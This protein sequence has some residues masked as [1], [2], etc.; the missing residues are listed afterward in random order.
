MIPVVLIV[1]TFFFPF[2]S[3]LPVLVALLLA[4]HWKTKMLYAGLFTWCIATLS[5]LYIPLPDM[6]MSRYYTLME[7]LNTQPIHA[8]LGFIWSNTDPISYTLMYIFQAPWSAPAL[9]SWMTVVVC[10]GLYFSIFIDRYRRKTL[11]LHMFAGVVLAFLSAFILFNAVSGVRFNIAVA[12]VVWT[13]YWLGVASRYK[14]ALYC[15]LAITPLIHSSMLGVVGLYAVVVLFRHVRFLNVVLLTVGVAMSI[16]V[17][18]GLAQYISFMPF[19]NEVET[20]AVYYLQPY[21]PDGFWYISQIIT[22]SIALSFLVLSR[23]H[24][25]FVK[26][27]VLV[28]MVAFTQLGYFYVANRYFTIGI[29]G[30]LAA[31]DT[32][33]VKKFFS[34]WTYTLGYTAISMVVGINLLFQVVAIRT[35]DVRTPSG[36]IIFSSTHDIWREAVT[37]AR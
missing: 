32:S 8:T 20:R 34:H 4:R 28:M 22:A 9:I 10:Y 30:A 7:L 21:V 33:T 36:D 3:T 23:T 27:M 17:L 2:W 18:L 11:S 1:A 31:L 13:L 35:L 24:T 16:G 19:F 14:I 12:V 25:M 15:I 5:L 29:L 26:T 37:H 6:D